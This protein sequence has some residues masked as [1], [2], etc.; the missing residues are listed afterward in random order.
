MDAQ[1]RTESAN[2]QFVTIEQLFV[3]VASGRIE[4]FLLRRHIT[5]PRILRVRIR[6]RRRWD[7]LWIDVDTLACTE[8]LQSLIESMLT[9]L[10]DEVSPG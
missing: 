1:R 9:Q 3:L 8:N 4:A 5:N 6:N 10:L 7:E 2:V